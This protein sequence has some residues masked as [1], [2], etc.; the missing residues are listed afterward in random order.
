MDSGENIVEGCFLGVDSTGS[1]VLANYSGIE[2][3]DTPQ[4]IG[5]TVPQARNLASGNPFGNIGGVAISDP[6][7][8]FVEGN[9][10]GTDATGTLALGGGGFQSSGTATIVGGT[11]AGSG[12]LFSGNSL[13]VGFSEAPGNGFDPNSNL[14]QGNLIGTDP[15]GTVAVPNG[16]GIGLQQADQ[17][18]IGGTTPTARNV[19]SGNFGDGMAVFD[20][21]SANIVQGNYIG[22][23]ISGENAL[24]NGANGIDHA[25]LNNSANAAG[26]LIGG[27]SPGAGNVISA[28]GSNGLLFGGQ[29]ITNIAGSLNNMGATVLGN[30]IGTD[31]TGT[32]PMPNGAAGVSIIE[33]GA[34]YTIGGTDT[35]A[36]NV[37]AFNQSDGV[38]I[39]PANLGS[40]FTANNGPNSVIGNAI[41]SN[42]G[43]GV[44][45]LSG[46]NNR[47]SQNSTYGN[48][49][50]GIDLGA[51]GPQTNTK[52]QTTTNGPNNLQNSPLLVGASGGTVLV[53]ATATGPSGN[54]SEFSNCA[55]MAVA[56][57]AI[58]IVGSL[59]SLP[60]TA[61]TIEFFANSSCDPSGFGQGRTFLGSLNVTTDTSS[62]CLA[63]F[64]I[65][66]NTGQA[67]LSLAMGT[68]DSNLNPGLPAIYVATVTNLGAGAA[69]AVSFTNSLPSS[70]SFVS[71][72]T[73]Q[74]TCTNNGNALTCNLGTMASGATAAITVTATAVDVGSIVDPASVS[75]STPDPNANNNSASVTFNS[76]NPFPVIDHFNPPN[77]VAGSG[78]TT[79]YIFG[80]GFISGTT[81]TVNST[82]LT[83]TLNNN[84]VC[85]NEFETTTCQFLTVTVPAPL[86][87][88]PANLSVSVANPSPGG[89]SSNMP[90]TVYPNPGTVTHFQISGIPNPALETTTFETN[91]YTMTVTALDANN[92]VV[93][94]YQGIVNL[95]D[96][97]TIYGSV[98]TPGQS[99]TPAPPYHFTANDHGVAS[100]TTTIQTIGSNTTEVYDIGT[101]SITS[102][103]T[104]NVNPVYGPPARVI[105]GQTPSSVPIGLVFPTPLTVTVVDSADNPLQGLTVT[106]TAPSS[107]SA[108]SCTFSNGQS[109]IQLTTDVNG[110][111]SATI[112]ANQ[113]AGQFAVGVTVG[114]LTAQFFPTSTSN[115]PASISIVDGNPQSAPVNT[116]FTG[117]LDVLVKDA[118]G[119]AVPNVTVT[120]SPPSAGAGVN[121]ASTTAVTAAFAQGF[122]VAG[123]ARLDPIGVANGTAGSY[124]LTASV[125]GLSTQFD[126]T[127]TPN[128]GAVATLE[129]HSG[130]PQSTLLNTQFATP[131]VAIPLDADFNCLAQVPVTFTAPPSTGPSATLSAAT[132]NSDPATC[133]AMV[134]ATAN[135]NKGGP[136]NVTATAGGKTATFSLINNAGTS[137]SFTAAYGTPQATAVGTAFAQPL[138]VLLLDQNGYPLTGQTV[139]FSTPVQ[140]PTATLSKSSALTDVNG[141]AQVTASANTLLGTFPVTA[142][143]FPTNGNTLTTTFLLTNT[144]PTIATVKATGGNPQAAQIGQP[145]AQPL[146]ATVKDS[147][148]NP[149][150]GVTVTFTAPTQGAGA[151]LSSSTAV[152]NAQGVASVNATANGTVGQ[153]FVGASVG[154]LADSFYLTN[155]AGPPA[156]LALSGT[157][158]STLLN[159]KFG[160]PLQVTVTDAAGNPVIGATVTFSVPGSGASATLSFQ[161]AITNGNGVATVTA[162]ANGSAGTY[163]VN[164]A[165]G[166]VTGKFILTNS[167]YSPCDVNQDTQTDVKDVQLMVNQSLGLAPANDLDNDKIVNVV[168]IQI[169]VNAVLKLGC[170]AQ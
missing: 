93:P 161:S 124:K 38:R 15:T 129:A 79:L 120:F 83:A 11:A 1:T 68:Q 20:A 159:T 153:F 144:A 97:L 21:S 84:G 60:G 59:T 45:I 42:G 31:A 78:P 156:N 29:A 16:E 24:S 44:R 88:S 85:G 130:T 133:Q 123:E 13:G 19:I 72:A 4:T 3:F 98:V 2:W 145:Y 70:L 51:S 61:Y 48:T 10:A 136:Y 125:G 27:E 116:Q 121:L 74:G 6:N 69:S 92:Q 82:V 166:P 103:L 146:A 108:P 167:A 43:S 155:T 107:A 17:N 170:E 67:D 115:V 7:T 104:V 55:A 52:C 100:F 89:G 39:D 41:Y 122:V 135:G 87:T 12:N 105:P 86:M 64:G 46:V 76:T 150:S 62:N 75:S 148:G 94:G 96:N 65:N 73:T 25:N 158:Q 101:P 91:S 111:V 169:V 23:D 119:N 138:R 157:P 58:N 36:A 50:L 151:T 147:A 56:S 77:G 37:I 132:V 9:Y 113:V 149:M 81:V 110:M 142:T 106:F 126:F 134:T 128:E 8:F 109:S 28:N 14:V 112:T 95:T 114:S 139:N 22:M 49:G 71:A 54:T 26:T 63:T 33:N 143:Y 30:L 163:Q 137:D 164:V 57:G 66:P 5:G 152:T 18:T 34:N 35:P 127:N 99:F 162:T 160:A 140:G 47:V 168:D 117:L 118:Q 165:A 80:L 141:N 102:S 40:A 53:S 131:L 154:N 32:V 90:W